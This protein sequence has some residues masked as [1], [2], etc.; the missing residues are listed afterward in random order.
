MLTS[1]VRIGYTPSDTMREQRVKSGFALAMFGIM[2]FSFQLILVEER[3]SLELMIDWLAILATTGA[4]VILQIFKRTDFAFIFVAGLGFI[5]L[6]ASLLLLG[7]R[8]GDLFF[9]PII[10]VFAVAVLGAKRSIPWFVATVILVVI[11]V[12]SHSV[13]PDL[14]SS[15]HRSQEDPQG[16]L[17]RGP[18]KIPITLDQLIGFLTGLSL[19]YLLV[20]LAYSALHQANE[21]IE[22]LLLNILP[23]SIANRLTDETRQK[24]REEGAGI[25]DEFSESTILFADIVGFTELTEKT[26]TTELMK[27]LDQVFTEFDHLAD[28]HEVEKI[29]TIGDAYM[30]VCGLPECNPNHAENI[31]N[32]ALEMLEAV[33]RYRERSGIPI[34]LRIGIN[35]GPVTAGI[36][37]RRKF[38]YDLWGDAVNV[39]SRM[40]SHGVPDTIQ[41]SLGTYEILDD[42]Y[43]LQ[44]LGNIYV[45]GKGQLPAWRLIGSKKI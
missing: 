25:A 2:L 32:M 10:P 12:T 24:L 36:I 18:A 16:L 29:K 44:P 42:A 21:R 5:V 40:E 38:I 1:Y 37:G 30:A 31:A 19:I 15:L 22:N 6:T 33:S 26:T 7:N 45:K 9:Y 27:I 3:T 34:H 43:E 13:L 14:A 35:S 17:F 4:L 41:M 8:N 11:A 23:P 20:Y 28:K 39:A